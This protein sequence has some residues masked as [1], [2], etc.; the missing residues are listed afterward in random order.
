MPDLVVSAIIATPVGPLELEDRPGGYT[1]AK[2]SFATRTVSFRKQ[3]VSTIFVGGTHLVRAAPD[4]VTEQ[5][6]V[7]V[8]GATQAELYARKKALTDGLSQL[9]YQVTLTFADHQEVWSCFTA[10]WTEQ[11]EQEWRIA[12]TSQVRA[13][14]PRLPNMAVSVV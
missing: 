5:L 11:E 4:N 1:L 9:T 3:E 10:G 13:Q 6:V 2:D 7:D 8:T 12:R 14:V